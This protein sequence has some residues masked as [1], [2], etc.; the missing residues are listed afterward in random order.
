MKHPSHFVGHDVEW[1]K[2]IYTLHAANTQ[3]LNANSTP[4]VQQ[5]TT[6]QTFN[7]FLCIYTK[8][9]YCH[10]STSN[11]LLRKSINFLKDNQTL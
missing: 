1:I 10:L 3:G 2:C 6:P 4:N 8:G 11:S 9:G 5:L 7:C